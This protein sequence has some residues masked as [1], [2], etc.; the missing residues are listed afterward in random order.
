MVTIDSMTTKGLITKLLVFNVAMAIIFILIYHYTLTL[1]N[2][3]QNWHYWFFGFTVSP[4]R[5]IQVIYLVFNFPL[6][7]FLVTFLVDIYGLIKIRK[8]KE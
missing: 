2:S 8:S 7:I 3:S 4:G 6:I 5:G 1:L